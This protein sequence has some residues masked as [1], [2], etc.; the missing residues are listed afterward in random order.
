MKHIYRAGSQLT[1]V[2]FMIAF[3]ALCAAG[4]LYWGWVLFNSYGTAPGDG[5]VLAPIGQ[6]IAWGLGVAA[7]GFAFLAGMWVY[8]RL[9]A[10]SIAYDDAADALHIRTLEF[11]ASREQVFPASAV[12]RSGYQHGRMDTVHGHSVNA[13]WFNLRLE[14]RSWPIIVDAQGEFPDPELAA[15]L[16]KLS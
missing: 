13:P 4:A 11:L 14:G 3:A 7:L 8:G 2:K 9:Y 16:L 5:G 6:R 12:Q 1:K 10:T 15:R